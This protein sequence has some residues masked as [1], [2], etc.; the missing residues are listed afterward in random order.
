LLTAIGLDVDWVIPRAPFDE[1][2]KRLTEAAGLVRQA[3]KET[4]EL[5]ASLR[6][7]ARDGEGLI[8]AI[9]AYAMEFAKRTGLALDFRNELPERLNLAQELSRNVYRIAQEALSNI[10][11]HAAAKHI[12]ITFARTEQGFAMIVTDD[13]R[14]FDPP[15]VSDPHEVGLVGMRERALLIGANLGIQSQVGNG[16]SIHLQVPTS[17]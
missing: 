7:G 3:I 11:R 10:A 6:T 4:R 16:T 15:S 5:C 12:E 8:E 1:S 9:H 2:R 14:G 13:G 17:G